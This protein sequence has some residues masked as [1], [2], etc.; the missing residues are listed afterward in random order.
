MARFQFAVYQQ[1]L[2][3]LTSP[4]GI[5]DSL[6]INSAQFSFKSD[7]WTGVEKWAHFTNY[8]SGESCIFNLINDEIG[9]NRNFNLKSGLW[10]VYLHGEV[11]DGETCIRRLVTNPQTIRIVGADIQDDQP[12]GEIVPSV[13]EQIDAKASAAINAR[14]TGATVDVTSGVGIPAAS[15]EITG[16]D[17]EKVLNFHFENLKGETGETGATG[18][19]GATPNLSIG[20]VE[21]VAEGMPATVSLTGTPEAPI[22]N[23]GIPVGATGATGATGQ[24]GAT[25]ATGE[26]GVAISDTAPTNPAVRVWI[27]NSGDT[28]VLKLRNGEEWESVPAIQGEQGETGETGAT[29]QFSVGS[30]TT[31]PEGSPATVSITGTAE[32]PVL[33]LGIPV[34]AT[35][36]TGETGATGATGATGQQGPRGPM[37]EISVGTVTT[38]AENFP[39]TVTITGP[40][41]APVLNFGIPIGHT[42]ATGAT[43]PVAA[44]S[45]G[46]VT[47]G[48]TAAA[49]ITGTDAAPVLNLVLPKGDPGERGADGAQ[50]I[51]PQFIIGTVTQG[52]AVDVT[53][54]GTPANP[55][56]NFTLQKGDRGPQGATGDPGMTPSFSIGTVV[57]GAD[58]SATI[59]GTDANPVLNLVLP[60][61]DT[62]ATGATGQ[63]GATGATPDI[64]IGTVQR[65]NDAAASITG[66]PENPLLNLTLPKG[67]T[68]ATGATPDIGIGTVQTLQPGASATASITGTTPNLTLNLGLPQ[69]ATGA[70][71]ATPNIQIGTVTTGDTGDPA[72]ASITGTPENPLLNLTLPKGNTGSTGQTGQTGA[73]PNIQIGTVTTGDTGDPAAASIA[74][75]PENPL[76]NLT[77]PKG[78]TGSTGQTGATPDIQIGTVQ[79][80]QPN[81]PATASIT[82]TTPNLTLN[83]GLPKGA[84]GGGVPNGGTAGQVLIKNSSTDQD[85]T[86]GSSAGFAPDVVNENLLFDPLVTPDPGTPTL[87]PWKPVTRYSR[88][89]NYCL[90]ANGTS[91]Y[92]VT[93]SLY[94]YHVFAGETVHLDLPAVETSSGVTYMFQRLSSSVPTGATNA[95]L[96]GTTVTGAVDDYVTVPSG[97]NPDD[98]IYL[99]VCQLSSDR[100]NHVFF[101]AEEPPAAVSKTTLF[102]ADVY[103]IK[104]PEAR[105][106]VAVGYVTG[107]T[108][109]GSTAYVNVKAE[110][111]TALEDGVAMILINTDFDITGSGVSITINVNSLGLKP[112]WTQSNLNTFST[113]AMFKR[114]F[115][116][117]IVY[118]ED[119]GITSSG[120][121][122]SNLGAWIAPAGYIPVAASVDSS[123]YPVSSNA[124]R[125][126]VTN[127][128][129]AAAPDSNGYIYVVD[130]PPE[131]IWSSTYNSYF[132][133]LPNV[134]SWYAIY[135]LEGITQD[136]DGPDYLYFYTNYNA[137]DDSHVNLY[138]AM[139]HDGYY[140]IEMEWD[141]SAY[142]Y[143]I[144]WY[145]RSITVSGTELTVN[146]VTSLSASSTDIE[147]PSAKCV[148]DLVGNVEAALAALR[149]SV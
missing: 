146:K 61:G 120:Y 101:P 35:G 48:D 76:L 116:T 113:G 70:T 4:T 136:Y 50:G 125:S 82:G 56:L 89:F 100:E 118:S 115:C 119:Y 131:G 65:G 114:N 46:T 41:Q 128:L 75:T 49:T 83:L 23:F 127:S 135:P 60:K 106:K 14:I 149:G 94:V 33:N 77:L 110:G 34:G 142:A 148:Y 97:V 45:I 117:W 10:D 81:Q 72:A 6:N 2:D 90:T 80:L 122:R 137:S 87:V 59:T 44:F 103:D 21:T 130:L 73:T 29:P 31:L 99:V 104:D 144:R 58:A 19:T 74:G 39:A 138:S 11:L 27:D 143:K 40:P 52:A 109:D 51:T 92:N 132:N 16:A 79:T 22:I 36:A 84:D 37:P 28:D 17:R 124:V 98:S 147:Y 64:Q 18:Q 139:F 3:L 133:D 140:E 20:D 129:H 5:A 68:G 121:Q 123:S 55:I 111:I 107:V 66:T 88:T 42:G 12:L 43:G 96:I 25:G 105:T 32:N 85:V 71:G 30:V 7:D 108:I 93:Y 13:A 26:S 63:T 145:F 95:N 86:W 102:N 15:V 78:N 91:A 112:F 24:T 141:S 8:D 62:G 47:G 134:D 1:N 69:G 38:L 53:I 126:Y 54:S 67:D 57:R 9:T